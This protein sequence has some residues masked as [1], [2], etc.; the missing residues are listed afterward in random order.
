MVYGWIFASHQLG[1]A[2]AAFGAGYIRTRYDD[3][4]LAFA[5]AAGLCLI[6][7]LMSLR[8]GLNAKTPEPI[9]GEGLSA[10][11]TA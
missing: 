2:F 5:A 4:T 7:S 8:I 1:A 11:S 9:L 3:Y 6:A 10:R